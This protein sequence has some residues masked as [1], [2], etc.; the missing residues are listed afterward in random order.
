MGA[1]DTGKVT[2]EASRPRHAPGARSSPEASKTSAGELLEAVEASSQSHSNIE[3]IRSILFG[4][5]MRDYE[6]RFACSEAQVSQES[7]DLRA[8]FRRRFES[9]RAM[10]DRKSMPLTSA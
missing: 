1:Y 10:Y 8:D 7:A 2:E 3:K 5:Q 6:A 9:W 4:N